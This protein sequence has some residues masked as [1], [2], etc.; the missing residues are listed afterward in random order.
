VESGLIPCLVGS[1]GYFLPWMGIEKMKQHWRNLV[2]RYG[3][4]PVIWC[5]AGEGSMPYYLS[6]DKDIEKVFLK[7]GWTEIAIY[8]RQIDPFQHPVTI[9]PVSSSRDTLSDDS[10]L[11]FDMLQTGHGDRSSLS[12]TVRL[13]QK[14]YARR[15]HMPVINGEV[16]YEGIGGGCH[17]DVQRLMLWAC[18]LNGAAGHT[19]G[20][21]GIWQ[22]NTREKP[23]GPSPHGMSWGNLPWEDAYQ[24]PGSKQLG[25]AVKLLKRYKWWRIEPHPEWV[26]PHFTEFDYLKP[27]AAGIIGELRIFYFPV[28]QGGKILIREIEPGI[29]YQALL[30]D[31]VNGSEIMLGKAEGDSNGQWVL[32]EGYDVTG[33][34]VFPI[35]QDWVLVME[36]TAASG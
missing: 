5:L 4:Y 10:V 23:Y 12:N 17:Q 31:P 7:N 34:F 6:R 32:Q 25:M 1:W 35:Y 27:Y 13:V 9:H 22:F 19:Y 30:F 21:N 26:E 8:L 11:D 15:P 2:A 3:A 18:I 24:L 28:F 33:R 14:D 29:T 16:C 20:A 36:K